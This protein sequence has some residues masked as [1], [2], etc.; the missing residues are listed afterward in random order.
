MK[1][2][3]LYLL[4]TVKGAGVYFSHSPTAQAHI[5]RVS[6]ATWYRRMKDPG[7]FTVSELRRLIA[8]YHIGSHELCDIFG[9]KEGS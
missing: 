9:V 3:D 7:S 5:A 4:K 1:K 2:E 8:Y 6:N